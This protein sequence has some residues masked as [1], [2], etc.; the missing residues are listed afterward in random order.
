M[1]F[2]SPSMD[3]ISHLKF[4]FNPLMTKF[5]YHIE[6]SQLI[7]IANQL[8]IFFMLGNIDR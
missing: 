2:L 7:W 8:T 3:Q 5:P 6:N 1:A 4:S